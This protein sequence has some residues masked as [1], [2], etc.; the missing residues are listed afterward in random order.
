MGLTLTT[1]MV[2]TPLVTKLLSY[3]YYPLSASYSFL[4][5]L[6]IYSADDNVTQLGNRPRPGKW[7]LF[8]WKNGREWW[9]AKHKDSSAPHEE[10]HQKV[11]HD[12]FLFFFCSW[13]HYIIYLFFGYQLMLT[14][15]WPRL[16]FF[17]LVGLEVWLPFVI[18]RIWRWE[19]LLFAKF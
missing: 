19:C 4:F 2:S 11:R 5:H 7:M 15:S 3:W 18:L 10:I 12:T 1:S 14:Q 8:S 6:L 17:V 9:S 16:A 13:Y